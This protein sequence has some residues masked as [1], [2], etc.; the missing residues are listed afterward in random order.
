ME[1]ERERE[2]TKITLFASFFKF[3]FMFYPLFVLISS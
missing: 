2:A 1:R 3:S